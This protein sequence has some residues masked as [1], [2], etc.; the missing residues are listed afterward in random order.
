MAAMRIHKMSEIPDVHR[1]AWI[2]EGR[3]IGRQ[4]AETEGGGRHN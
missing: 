2:E 1:K 4:T 3:E